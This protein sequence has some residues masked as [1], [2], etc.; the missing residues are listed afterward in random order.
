MVP[1]YIIMIDLHEVI[2]K[3]GLHPERVI[4]VYLFGS[5]CYGTES[6][7]SDY[8]I[9]IIAKTPWPEREIISGNYNIHI[10]SMDRFLEGLKTHNIRN[11]EC[12]FSPIKFITQKIDYIVNIKGLRHSISHIVS[13][14]WVKARKKIENGEYYIGT[15]SLFHS[16]R[17]LMFGQ[18]LA[19]KGYIHDWKCANDVWIE[20]KSK[21][22]TWEELNKKYC[23]LKNK[24][25]TEFRHKTHK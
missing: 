8:D 21:E 4:N 6:N 11:I 2:E 5:R 22:W 20:I 1:V 15:K 9:L 13:N 17:I 24:L 25:A 23:E 14:S 3:S 12:L 19:E 16:I 7:D 18:Q 10:L